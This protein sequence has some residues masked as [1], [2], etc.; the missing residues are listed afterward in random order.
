MGPM[1][2]SNRPFPH[3]TSVRTNNNI[4]FLYFCLPILDLAPLFVGMRERS[5]S[6]DFSNMVLNKGQ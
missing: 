6:Q 4:N 2:I 5:T 1:R 3:S